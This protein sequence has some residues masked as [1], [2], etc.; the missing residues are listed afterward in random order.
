VTA[1]APITRGGAEVKEQQGNK[2]DLFN[3]PVLN[4]IGNIFFFTIIFYIF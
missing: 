4:E 2:L 1:Y 3:D